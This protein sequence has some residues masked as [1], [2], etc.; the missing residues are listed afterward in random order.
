MFGGVLHWNYMCCSFN[1]ILT[2]EYQTE[3]INNFEG[4]GF[5]VPDSLKFIESIFTAIFTESRPTALIWWDFEDVSLAWLEGRQSGII[6]IPMFKQKN[7]TISKIH[8][9]I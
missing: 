2:C 3:Q 1:V 9:P 4:T 6:F 8:L 7:E 5:I